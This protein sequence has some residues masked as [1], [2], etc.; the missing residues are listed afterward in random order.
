MCLERSHQIAVWTEKLDNH[1]L[2][3]WG[4]LTLSQPLEQVWQ[5][6]TDYE[7]L[8]DFI[9]YLIKSQLIPQPDSKLRLEQIGSKSLLKVRFSIR[10]ILNVVEQF[11][12][13]IQFQIVEGD[14]HTLLGECRLQEDFD[15]T[16]THLYYS[17]QLEPKLAI[18]VVLLEKLIKK[19]LPLNL[20]AVKQRVREKYKQKQTMS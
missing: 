13:T 1:Q 2:R 16:L 8:P 14:F 20:L 3:V 7:A 17:V 5:V 4:K 19:Y 12:H 15:N 11:P 6:L 10:A 18:P 9:P